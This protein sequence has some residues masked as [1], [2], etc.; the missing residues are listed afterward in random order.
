LTTIS[1]EPDEDADEIPEEELVGRLIGA[2]PAKYIKAETQ[3]MADWPTTGTRPILL[4]IPEA[5]I[6]WFE[7]HSVSGIA[8]MA[9][10]LNS[11][12]SIHTETLSGQPTKA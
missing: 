6:S 3:P 8:E 10:V 9:M 1:D 12:V 4:D 2:G 7:A 11:W 5:T